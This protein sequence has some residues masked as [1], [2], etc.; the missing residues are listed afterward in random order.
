MRSRPCSGAAAAGRLDHSPLLMLAGHRDCHHT[1]YSTSLRWEERGRP[2]GSAGGSKPG[3]WM[4]GVVVQSK[5]H[6]TVSPRTFI[7]C[8]ATVDLQNDEGKFQL[9]AAK[10]K[11][12]PDLED[13]SPVET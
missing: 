6:V 4:N 7:Q 11:P 5:H 2:A 9:E 12:Q 13:C 8:L 10:S 3:V 1:P